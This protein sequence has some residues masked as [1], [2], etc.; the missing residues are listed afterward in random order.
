M[1][2]FP[3]TFCDPNHHFKVTAFFAFQF[4]KNIESWR[5]SYYRTLK[6]KSYQCYRMVPYLVTLTDWLKTRLAVCQHQLVVR[7]ASGT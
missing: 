2:T 3:M 1:V 6:Y 4:L 5:Q 7:S